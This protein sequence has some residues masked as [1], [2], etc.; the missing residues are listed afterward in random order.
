MTILIGTDFSPACASVAVTAAELARR[1]GEDVILAHVVE[2]PSFHSASKGI[3]ATDDVHALLQAHAHRLAAYGCRIRPLLEREGHCGQRLAQVAERENVRL[4]VVGAQG[5]GLRTPL[6]TT[7]TAL[8][9]HT[10]LPVLV[11]RQPQRL[12][13]AQS[14]ARLTALVALA[15][16]ATD[17]GLLDALG[18]VA[19]TGDFDADFVHYRPLPALAKWSVAEPLTNHELRDYF[20]D[21]PVELG[22]RSVFARDRLGEVDAHLNELA[23]ER[24]VDLVVCGSHHRH[25]IDRVL[26][27]SIAEGVVMRSP[28]S[29]LV[30][31]APTPQ[32]QSFEQGH[33]GA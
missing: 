27:G 13:S 12:W 22:V 14:D 17:E 32:Q 29:V 19:G 7:A 24:N 28:V 26:H 10:S 4:L 20:G 9:R 21:L 16:D 30:A 2:G 25:G 18:I 31:R 23:R 1:R 8:L 11:V 6:G 33:H 5:A 15:L 3:A